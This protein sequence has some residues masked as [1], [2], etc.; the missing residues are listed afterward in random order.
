MEL[1]KFCL[2]CFDEFFEMWN[3]IREKVNQSWKKRS[4]W[5][6][7][8]TESKDEKMRQKPLGRHSIQE[9]D[10]KSRLSTLGLWCRCGKGP[11]SERSRPPQ[12]KR[13]PQPLRLLP[14]WTELQKPP[15]FCHITLK[16]TSVTKP[17]TK[18]Y[19]S[20]SSIQRWKNS[21][22][23]AL[24]YGS[25]V[26]LMMQSFIKNGKSCPSGG[27]FV[28]EACGYALYI[29]WSCINTLP[30]QLEKTRL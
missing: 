7:A 16:K 6:S 18:M 12:K 2:R 8:F 14:S 21:K 25:N 29:H 5:T 11:N 27:P 28:E 24:H 20:L 23:K 1:C 17:S 30:C 3:S 22:F 9:D 13:W 19:N 26:S 10:R 15:S 4:P